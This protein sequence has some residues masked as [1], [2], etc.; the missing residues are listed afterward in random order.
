M[1]YH[2][3]AYTMAGDFVAAVGRFTTIAA[4]RKAMM[5]HS[6]TAGLPIDP[7]TCIPDCGIIEDWFVGETEY[8]IQVGV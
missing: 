6:G 7:P 4:A 3:N 1:G 5:D 8:A 2:L